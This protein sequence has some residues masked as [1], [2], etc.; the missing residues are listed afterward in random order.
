[1]SGIKVQEKLSRAG[2]YVPIVFVTGHEDVAIA[3]RAMKAGAIDFLTKPFRS[4]DLLD[5]DF[6]GLEWDSARRKKQQ[7]HSTVREHF[8]S[9]SARE[10]EVIAIVAAGNLNKQIAAELGLSEV[11]VKVHRASAMRKMHATTLAHVI[12]MLEHVEQCDMTSRDCRPV[13][14]EQVRSFVG[15]SGNRLGKTVSLASE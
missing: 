6:A 5:A 4:Q 12:T 8:E 2:V 3:V 13:V 15:F 7:L 9:L 1:M 11:T 14:L 10:K